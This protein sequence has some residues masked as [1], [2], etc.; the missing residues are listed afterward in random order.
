M[1]SFLVAMHLYQLV[2]WRRVFIPVWLGLRVLLMHQ[3]LKKKHSKYRV[4]PATG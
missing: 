1:P 4:L 2:Q 3:K